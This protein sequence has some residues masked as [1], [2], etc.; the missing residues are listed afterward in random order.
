MEHG[1][2]PRTLYRRVARRRPLTVAEMLAIARLYRAAHRPRRRVAKRLIGKPARWLFNLAYHG[3]KLEGAGT[4][5]MD[6]VGPLA[7]NG[8]N[9]QFC[10]LYMP[11]YAAG[12]EPET[13]A[14]IDALM[15]DGGV[16]YD[17]GANFGYYS[18]FVGGRAGFTGQVHAFE[19]MAATFA[20]LESLIVQAGLGERATCHKV[21]ISDTAGEAEMSIGD[22]LHSGIA[23]LGAGAG[24]KVPLVMLDGLDLE[25]P[26]LINLDVEDHEAQALRSADKILAE[27]RPFVV[28]E[29]WREAH[30]PDHT[31]EPLRELTRRD[32]VLFQPA[33]RVESGGTAWIGETPPEGATATLALVPLVP[34]QRFLL[35]VQINLL[36]CPRDRL[37]DLAGIFADD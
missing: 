12:Y 14:L 17:V 26:A 16:F 6:G 2:S 21:A 32:Y 13:S 33:W 18:L 15:P 24:E 1:D 22:G 20:D 30:R 25:P 4:L 29:S 28:L 9:T 7:F 36:A 31:L 8:R 19:P 5:D 34:E 37:A 3:L 10:G 27:H 35:G 23:R 11:Q